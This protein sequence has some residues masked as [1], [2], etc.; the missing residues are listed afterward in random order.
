MASGKI[1]PGKDVA[2]KQNG[3]VNWITPVIS[4][5]HVLWVTNSSQ[6]INDD[7]DDDDKTMEGE[8][9]GLKNTS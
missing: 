3:G 8:R 2:A 7:D 4:S 1:L 9:K 5:F 6:N